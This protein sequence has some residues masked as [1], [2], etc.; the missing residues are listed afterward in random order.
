MA[1]KFSEKIEGP[2]TH[3]RTEFNAVSIPYLYFPW[4]KVVEEH[5]LQ[6]NSL[7]ESFDVLQKMVYTFQVFVYPML[8]VLLL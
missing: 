7:E 5:L 1:A 2:G 8:K 4:N 3:C 6:A